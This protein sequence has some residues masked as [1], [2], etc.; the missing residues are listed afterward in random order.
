MVVGERI[1]QLIRDR[2]EARNKVIWGFYEEEYPQYTDRAL[3]KGRVCEL[4]EE[5]G[6]DEINALVVRLKDMVEVLRQIA[7]TNTQFAAQSVLD[8]YGFSWEQP[9]EHPTV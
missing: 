5:V 7:R 3:E 1:L 6:A 2:D 9:Y 4:H 8:K